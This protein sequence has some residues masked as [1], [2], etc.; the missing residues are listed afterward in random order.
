MSGRRKIATDIRARVAELAGQRCSYCQSPGLIGI[1]MVIDHIIPLSAGGT[2][3]IDNLCLSCY[4]CNEFKGDKQQ[5]LNPL[6]HTVVTL[7]RPRQQHWSDHFA[8]SRDGL[9]IIGLTA[10]GRATVEVLH[11]NDPRLIQARQIWILVGLHP[12]LS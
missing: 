9:T 3:E 2:S 7:F 1:P 8:W 6:T 4:R 5:S 12:P 11:F 10:C